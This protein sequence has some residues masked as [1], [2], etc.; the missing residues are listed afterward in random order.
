M[1][2]ASKPPSTRSGRWFL[3]LLGLSLALIGGVFV[4][5]MGRSFLRAWD[6]RKWPEVKCV[7]IQS[8]IGERRHDDF[9]PIEYRQNLTFG[10]EWKGQAYTGTHL[11]LRDNPWSSKR[12][13]VEQ[14]LEELP[15]GAE[16]TCRV[17][18]ASPEIAVL[19]PDSL[20][21]GYSIWFPCLFV[22]GGLGISI[23]AMRG[24]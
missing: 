1:N 12:E 22:I 18:P 6:M 11:T 4:A 8:E 24:A 17:N 19:K 20:A 13:L 23:R 5:L 2:N 15:L 7:V 10:Y 21:P 3:A 14:R 9:S 16:T